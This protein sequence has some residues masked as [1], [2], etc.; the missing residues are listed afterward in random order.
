MP[1]DSF[2]SRTSVFV[3]SPACEMCVPDDTNYASTL[4]SM[5]T[6][7]TLCMCTVQHGRLPDGS[8]KKIRNHL[9]LSI[10]WEGTGNSTISCILDHSSRRQLSHMFRYPATIRVMHVESFSF[11]GFQVGTPRC[12]KHVLG[13]MNFQAVNDDTLGA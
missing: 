7:V 12:H 3:S 11:L 2:V 10:W 4:Q 5:R 8:G 1:S 9:A 6:C 13:T